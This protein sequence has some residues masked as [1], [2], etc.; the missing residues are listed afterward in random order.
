MI[1]DIKQKLVDLIEL[2]EELIKELELLDNDESVILYN[3]LKTLR[4]KSLR[5]IEN[6]NLELQAEKI[7]ECNHIMVT[8][9]YENW[10]LDQLISKGEFDICVKCGLDSYFFKEFKATGRMRKYHEFL[11]TEFEKIPE[12]CFTGIYTNEENPKEVYQELISRYPDITDEEA[13]EKLKVLLAEDLQIYY[14]VPD[15]SLIKKLKN[16]IEPLFSRKKR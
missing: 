1:D 8:M 5:E 16:K 13:I 2:D 11:K 14:I 10:G 6:L 12:E 4:T 7:K 9:P 15:N 3:N